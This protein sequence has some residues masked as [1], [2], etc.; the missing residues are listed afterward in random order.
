MAKKTHPS[1]RL[2][3]R[4]QRTYF[5]GQCSKKYSYAYEKTGEDPWIDMKPV[6]SEQEVLNFYS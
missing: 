1:C 5:I 3:L 6:A 2:R 4:S